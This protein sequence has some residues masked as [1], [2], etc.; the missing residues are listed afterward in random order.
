MGLYGTIYVLSL[1]F[2]NIASLVNFTI[3]D[4]FYLVGEPVNS[5][6]LN[7]ND[8]KL[9]KLKC[10]IH[11]LDNSSHY[12]TLKADTLGLPPELDDSLSE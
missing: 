7:V 4:L 5:S 2:Y 3:D 12:N 1:N 8:L 6:Q 10:P 11:R 9:G